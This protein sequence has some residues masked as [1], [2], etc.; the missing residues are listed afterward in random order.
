M[1]EFATYAGGWEHTALAYQASAD[2][3]SPT[4]RAEATEAIGCFEGLRNSGVFGTD[5][6]SNCNILAG[7]L[8]RRTVSR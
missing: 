3:D 2:G 1:G 6:T 4:F 7:L 5:A 8:S